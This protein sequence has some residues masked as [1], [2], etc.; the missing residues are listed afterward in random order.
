V[1]TIQS[2]NNQIIVNYFAVARLA[3]RQQLLVISI[4]GK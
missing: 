1:G 2:I 3:G 4:L